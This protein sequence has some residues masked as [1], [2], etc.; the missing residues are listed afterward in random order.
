GR[1][2]GSYSINHLGGRTQ[3][4]S[5]LDFS[6]AVQQS[7]T[8]HKRLD[9]DTDKVI[10]E[11][12][13]Y[14]HQNR[15]LTHTHQVDSNPVE[16]LAQNDYN[17][18]SQLRNK[19][20][21]GTNAGSPLQSID[22]AYN[23]HGWMTKVNDPLNLN[24]KLFGYEIKYNNPIYNSFGSARYN[25]NIAEVEWK[26]ASEDV[27]KRYTY[28][29]DGLNR[30]KDAIYTEPFSTI[31]F[32]Y[33]FNEHLTYD[34][35]G[36]IA[37][38][39]RNAIPFSGTTSLQVDDLVYQYTGNR[40]DRII[41]NSLN[42]TGYEGGNNIIDYDLN[43]N[44]INMKDKGIQS[45]AYNSLSLPNSFYIEQNAF[46]LINFINISH[47][48]SANGQKLRKYYSTRPPRGLTTTNITD[49]LDGFQYKYREGGGICITCRTSTAY[50]EQAYKDK[51]IP[52]FP[53]I[54]PIWILDF[55]ATS[56][57]FYSFAENR[58]IYQYKDHLGNA[59]VSFAKDTGQDIQTIDTNN[60][61]PFGLNH[62]GGTSSST[63]GSFYSYKYNGKELQE[64]GMY[65]YGARF[66]MPDIGRWGVVDPLA[67]V[68][69]AW[70]PYRYAFNNPLRFIDPDGRSE[71]DWIRKDGKWQFNAS[72]TTVEQAQKISGVDGFAKNGT[73]LADAKIGANGEAGYVRLSEGGKASYEP[74][75]GAINAFQ[76]AM[77]MFAGGTWTTWPAEDFPSFTT[78]LMSRDFDAGSWSKKLPDDK[79]LNVNFDDFV[80]PST[81]PEKVGGGLLYA[82]AQAMSRVG[83]LTSML[84]G[85]AEKGM[86]KEELQN[87]MGVKVTSLDS[88]KQTGFT[89]QKDTTIFYGNRPGDFDKAY[90]PVQDTS[91]NRDIRNFNSRVPSQYRIN[92][93]R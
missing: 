67:E 70:S 20:V 32:N 89:Y 58:Y 91:Y 23:I 83:D 11:N 28:S 90:K 47:L 65:D 75:Y 4:F 16:Y 21:G 38:L 22:Y 27:L 15:L 45:I 9:T 41:E 2:I 79:V 7:I 6:G 92:N 39:K 50:E 66:Y 57:G 31:P 88:I 74:M 62:I 81:F 73:V 17:E 85:T 86:Q 36:N 84:Y 64:T 51:L 5:K 48:Y 82:F 24:G 93:K 80:S 29:Y 44:M 69:R 25:G 3:V 53:D 49:Y 14:D 18:L 19:K 40:L 76:S 10:T 46:G 55:V 26:N 42:D 56:E 63:F 35:N 33:N 87:S 60:Y 72:V 13:T 12:F 78:S 37:T 8:K 43:G 61:Y 68:N 1:A 52:S 30:L 59:R 77:P 71:S 54:E 34:V